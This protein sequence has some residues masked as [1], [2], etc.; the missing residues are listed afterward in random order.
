MTR[1]SDVVSLLHVEQHVVEYLSI[2]KLPENDWHG[3]QRKNDKY[4]DGVKRNSLRIMRRL[5]VVIAQLKPLTRPQTSETEKNDR[6]HY[7][8]RRSI[9]QSHTSVHK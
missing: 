8:H 4:I 6:E 1:K 7:G 2:S 3:K 5:F 9:D